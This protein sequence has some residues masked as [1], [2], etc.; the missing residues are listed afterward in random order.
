MEPDPSETGNPIP[1]ERLQRFREKAAE[2]L[3][4]N[5][6]KRAEPPRHVTPPLF[7]EVYAEGVL[8]LDSLAGEPVPQGEVTV[9]VVPWP[10]SVAGEP[11]V[12]A[13]GDL[14]RIW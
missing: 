11:C 2:I 14:V 5:A 1:H 13:Q 4:R 10:D 12:R 6:R 9:E 7:D 3:A 8:W